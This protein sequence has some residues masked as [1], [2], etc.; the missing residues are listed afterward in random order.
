MFGRPGARQNITEK[1][2]L[3]ELRIRILSTFVL[4]GGIQATILVVVIV[5]SLLE[6]SF[7]EF[8]IKHIKMSV[9]C[10]LVPAL[11]GFPLLVYVTA[12]DIV[13]PNF[14]PL[15][16]VIRRT[17]PLWPGKDFIERVLSLL[18]GRFMK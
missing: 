10:L 4:V 9:A 1:G 17:S 11:I 16:E 8:V 2:R 5:F 15:N 14:E 6:Y 18:K 3:A 13:D 12:R 7:A